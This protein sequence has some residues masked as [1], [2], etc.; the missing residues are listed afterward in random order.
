MPL[1][2]IVTNTIIIFIHLISAAIAVGS[3]V[4]AVL[5]YLPRVENPKASENLDENS[6]SY[7][8]LDILAPTVFSSVLMLIGTGIYFLL[9][10]YSAQVG[11]KPGYYNLFGVKMIFVIAAFFLSGYQT[12][13][14]RGRIANLDLSPEKRELVPATLGTMKKT[15]HI[16]LALIM[17]AVFLGI[18]LARY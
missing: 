2:L 12:F 6:V 13:T 8:A 15:S 1:R 16:N 18:W 3:L 9:E 4:F 17:A 5:L 7:T 10:N 14:L 11:R